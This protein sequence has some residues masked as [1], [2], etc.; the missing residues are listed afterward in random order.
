MNSGHPLWLHKSPI[1]GILQEKMVKIVLH[2]SQGEESR[3]NAQ[4]FQRRCA[5]IKTVSGLR[6]S[7]VVVVGSNYTRVYLHGHVRVA[8][9]KAD[10]IYNG[11]G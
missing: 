9:K 1:Y 5:P 6:N 10:H 11:L 2:Y 3:K 7:A 4:N 8:L